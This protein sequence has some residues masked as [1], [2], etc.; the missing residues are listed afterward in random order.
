MPLEPGTVTDGL[1]VNAEAVGAVVGDLVSLGR[2]KKGRVIAGM[3]GFQSVHRIVE[4]PKMSKRMLGEA[5]VR[6]AKRSMPVSLDQLYLSWQTVREE[7]G[8]QHL[9]LV[10]TPRSMVDAEF[11]CFRKA[12]LRPRAMNLKPL[13]LAKLVDHADAL[14]VDMEPESCEIIVVAAGVPAIMRS[15]RLHWESGPA[16]WTRHVLEEFE[17]TLRFYES[18][19]PNVTI[20]PD[21]PLFLT[22]KLADEKDLA[23]AVAAGTGFNAQP[24]A[25]P[26]RCPSDLPA[27]LYA[28]NLGL[29]VKRAPGGVREEG[30]FVMTDLDV[31]P[32][33]YRARRISA[34]HGLVASGVVM[35]VALAVPMYQVADTATIEARMLNI[36]Y[37]VLEQSAAVRLARI[38]EARQVEEV[39]AQA[40]TRNAELLSVLRDYQVIADLRERAY[41][42]LRIAI[43]S[44]PGGALP[45]GV[46]LSAATQ[47]GTKLSLRG[48]AANYETAL[49]YADALRRLEG[50]S[51]VQVLTLEKSADSSD[52]VNF[53]IGLEWS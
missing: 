42:S 15:I 53:D 11:K 50:F 36:E 40:E 31:L 47:A 48:K 18:S 49:S 51:N 28:A 52:G 29:A 24:V 3:S 39:I 9:L 41:S 17:R 26:L 6:E 25:L 22:G 12:G 16:E 1:V 10:G 8:V 45:E 33:A 46:S 38:K 35:G 7:H 4:M 14:I 32:P 19:Y 5:V 30:A 2:L 43:T 34:K 44:A 23:Q 20:S 13:A 21:T 37:G 27:S